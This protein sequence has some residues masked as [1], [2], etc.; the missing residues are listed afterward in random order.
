MNKSKLIFTLFLLFSTL[1]HASDIFVAELTPFNGFVKLSHINNITFRPGYDNQPHF[2]SNGD[3][4][5]FTSMLN[6]DGKDQTDTMYYSFA[7]KSLKNITNTKNVSE[8]SPTPIYGDAALSMIIVEPDGVQR[9]WQ[10]Q[11]KT[12]AQT[13]INK[14]LKPIGYHAW[15]KNSDLVL[16]VLGE[17]MT[18]QY[19]ET[20]DQ[21]ETKII[22]EDIG[23]SLRYNKSKDIFTYTK[24]TE[25]Q[26]LHVFNPLRQSKQNLLPL[27]GKS[28]Y[29]TWLNDNQVISAS[30]T[31]IYIWNY[32]NSGQAKEH[33]WM[34]LAD[35][36]QYCS[37]EITRLA[38]DNQQ[39]KL[40]FVCEE[41]KI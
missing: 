21:S 24:G 3:G 31:T 39:Q 4:L 20:P 26:T 28:E 7:S 33:D 30:G 8:Y 17:K 22:D 10:T 23:R 41:E 14:T 34:P 35:L 40:A 27:P 5:F 36:S 13:L 32:D 19:I 29:Y 2:S 9:L 25:R 11:I 1:T 18:L 15:G 6:N 16:F 12:K 37:T 38:V